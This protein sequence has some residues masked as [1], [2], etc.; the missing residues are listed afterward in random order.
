[1]T[2][3]GQETVDLFGVK[4]RDEYDWEGTF[5]EEDMAARGLDA[6]P[7]GALPYRDDAA[8]LYAALLEYATATIEAHYGEGDAAAAAI[9]GDAQLQA[10]LADLSKG[11]DGEISGFPSP[12]DV[13]SVADLARTVAKVMWFGGGQHHTLNSNK[14]PNNDNTYPIAPGKIFK[15]S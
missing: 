1:M 3:A 12:A 2:S 15:V 4:L 14:M 5:L 9:K 13:K 10:F 6:I 8:P 7:A 11:G